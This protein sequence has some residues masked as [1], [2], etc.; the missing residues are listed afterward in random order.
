MMK[1]LIVED[2]FV[3]RTLLAELLSKFGSCDVAVNGKEA[4]EAFELAIQ[5]NEKYDL[6]CLD[7]MMPGMS[8][9]EVLKVIREIETKN[10]IYGLD[11]SKVVMTTALSDAENIRSAFH[12]QSD[13]YLVKPITKE[14]LIDMMQDLNLIE[15]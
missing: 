6:V 10:Q 1:I 7:I 11:T 13:G 14:K 12:E 2:E 15:L 9:Q 4:I 5:K 3:S 8:G